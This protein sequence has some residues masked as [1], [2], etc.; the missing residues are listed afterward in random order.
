[1]AEG[2]VVTVLPPVKCGVGVVPHRHSSSPAPRD[3]LHAG[4][5]RECPR[6]LLGSSQNDT[7]GS[8]HEFDLSQC[9]A[10]GWKRHGDRAALPAVGG[11]RQEFT[12]PQLFALS[13]YCL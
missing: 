3:L 5:A 2:N 9:P 12:V 7:E 4:G 1:M 8:L 13:S 6:S 11:G 10:G